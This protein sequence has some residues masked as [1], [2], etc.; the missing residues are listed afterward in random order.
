MNTQLATRTAHPLAA[1]PHSEAAPEPELYLTFMLGGEAYAVRI[2]SIKEII[3][4]GGVTPV[5]LM[6]PTIRGVI[7]LRGAVV[8]V[9]DLSLRFGR[10]ATVI[11]RRSCIVIAETGGSG[12]DDQRQVIGM[13]V[14]AV[15]AVQEIPPGEIEPAPAFGMKIA[16]EFIAGI[17][18]TG[19]RFA[20]VLDM[21]KVLSVAELAALVPEGLAAA[22][23]L[24]A[25][26]S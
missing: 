5:P 21:N 16:G 20:I 11:G 12:P 8:P 22:P 9:L 1:R 2:L 6:P 25:P 23:A 10:E 4:Y 17:G 15:N 26:R 18:K 7:N 24:E 14:D 13:V 3:E 19:G